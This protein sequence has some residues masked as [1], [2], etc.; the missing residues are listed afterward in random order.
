VPN[1]QLSIAACRQNANLTQKELAEKLSVSTTTIQNWETGKT[2]PK[3][4]HLRAISEL[5]GVPMDCIFLPVNP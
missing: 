2:Q 3:L 1:I 5:S 4:K